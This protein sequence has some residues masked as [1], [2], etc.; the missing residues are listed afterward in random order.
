MSTTPSARRNWPPTPALTLGLPL[1][2]LTPA[3]REVLSLNLPPGPPD[4]GLVWTGATNAIRLAETAAMLS[5]A[6]EV[7]GVVVVMSPNGP[8]DAAAVQ[9]LAACHSTMRVPLL[10][11]ILGETTGAPHRR[12]LA[13]AGVPVFATPEQTMRGFGQLVGPAPRPRRGAGAAG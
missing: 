1:A 3:T 8:G 10:A 4:A 5:A 2:D 7:G 11:C 6:P 13:D 12:I 9:A